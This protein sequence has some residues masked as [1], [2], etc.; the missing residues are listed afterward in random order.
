MRL[1]DI[2]TLS[3]LFVPRYDWPTLHTSL[4]SSPVGVRLIDIFT[5][6]GLF[7]PRYYLPTL[8]TS[9]HSSPVGVRLID[10]FT[11]SGLFDSRYDWPTQG[12]S[13]LSSPVG[14]R[15][16]KTQVWELMSQVHDQ[17]EVV[18]TSMSMIDWWSDDRWIGC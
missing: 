1:I 2:F 6:S 11:L 10:I 13:V 17:G 12:T 4:H 3:G 7:V 14:E 9:L 16:A 8:H 18:V 15:V 5:L